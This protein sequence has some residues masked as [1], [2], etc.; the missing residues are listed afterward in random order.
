[1][2]DKKMN[3]HASVKFAILITN[4]FPQYDVEEQEGTRHQTCCLVPVEGG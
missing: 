1:M 4:L 3:A 2:Q